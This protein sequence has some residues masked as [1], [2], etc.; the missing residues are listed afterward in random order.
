MSN[1]QL[2]FDGM[3][4]LLLPLLFINLSFAQE[5]KKAE[6]W[7][8]VT[9]KDDITVYTKTSKNS[10]IRALKALGL[11]NAPV[12]KILN[13][14]RD[15]DSASEWLPNLIERT[16]VKDISDT[17]AIIYEVS[18]LPWPVSD[19]EMVLHNKLSL[20]KD[21]KSII[22]YFKS[23]E[24][25]AKKPNDDYVRA[26][27]HY[28]KITFKPIGKTTHIEMILLADPMGSVPKWAVNVMQVSLPHNFI[29]SLNK[30]AGISKLEIRPG[31]KEL[32]SKLILDPT[33][34]KLIKGK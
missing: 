9:K 14:L 5:Q 15:V 33:G 32:V 19:R 23:V 27:V 31:I 29:M 16:H 10:P 11:V 17:E 4:L 12:D 21:K 2:K 18:D 8:Y 6:E 3:K 13:I 22:L 1:S 28:G 25:D 30:F 24:D 7:T 20:S 34:P 26:K